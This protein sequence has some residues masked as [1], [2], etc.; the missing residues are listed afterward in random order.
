MKRFSLFFIILSLTI[1]QSSAQSYY[2]SINGEQLAPD[3]T[4]T[5]T[6]DTVNPVELSFGLV[7]HNNTNLGANIKVLRNE[8]SML[9]GSSSFFRWVE[10]YSDTINLSLL[11]SFVPAGS[12]SV[13]GLFTGNYIPNGTVGVSIVEYTFFSIDDTAKNVKI[14]VAYDTTPQGIDD[15][16][17]TGLSVSNVYPNPA[18]SFVSVDYEFVNHVNDARAVIIN[19][20]GTVVMEKNISSAGNILTMD[21]SNLKTGIYFCSIVVDNQVVS[22]QKIIK[23]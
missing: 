9:E 13:E 16:K 3:T 10:D 21:I 1:L 19:L 7:F 20:L 23:R 14:T 11:S 15:N 8:I 2:L 4:I 22:S 6:S 18:H 5:I 17:F 12:S